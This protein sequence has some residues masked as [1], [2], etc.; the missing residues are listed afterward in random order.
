MIYR[1]LTCEIQSLGRKPRKKEPLKSQNAPWQ[2]KLQY[3]MK[4]GCGLYISDTNTDLKCYV[5]PTALNMKLTSSSTA[6][7]EV[8]SYATSQEILYL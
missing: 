2:H 7:L 5:T 8:N 4:G 3:V 6:I 1:H